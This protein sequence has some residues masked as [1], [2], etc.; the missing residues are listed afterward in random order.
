MDY[1]KRIE[2]TCRD[3]ILGHQLDKILESFALCNSQCRL[4]AYFTENHVY[5]ALVLKTIQKNAI[6]EILP[7]NIRELSL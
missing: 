2:Y 3:G 6:Q 4:Q 1:T 7:Y 5:S